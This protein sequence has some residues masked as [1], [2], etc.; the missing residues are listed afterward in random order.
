MA[1]LGTK[2]AK[3]V[4][5]VRQAGQQEPVEVVLMIWDVMGDGGFWE[6]LRDSYFMNAHGFL[7]VCDVTRPDTLSELEEWKEAVSDVA[8][9][10]PS[11]ILANKADLAEEAQLGP[12]EVVSLSRKWGCPYTFTSAKTGENVQRAFQELAQQILRC[13]H[14]A[15]ADI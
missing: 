5:E 7:A 10:I 13:D 12:A 15:E 6:L 11:C 2:I 3:K 1:T 8:G 14:G 9:R 4:L